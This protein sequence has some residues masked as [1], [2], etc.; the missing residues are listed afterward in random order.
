MRKTNQGGFTLIELL[1]VI[2]IIAILAAMLLPALNGAKQ[3]A[4]MII[5]LNNTKELGLAWAMYAPDN[6]DIVPIN[7]QYSLVGNWVLGVEDMSGS[8]P[9][10]TNTVE[11]TQGTINPYMNQNLA[12]Y[13]CP[14]DQSAAPGQSPR[15]R[16][17]SMNAFVGAVPFPGTTNYQNFLHMHDFRHTSTTYTIL[18]EHPD[19]INDG[20]YLPILTTSVTETTEWEDLAGSYHNHG[21]SFVYADGHSEEHHWQVAGTSKPITGTYS[22]FP[23]APPTDLAWMI[24]HMSPTE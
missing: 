22:A 9:V 6:Q 5:C 2:A 10:N 7:E 23:A 12:S 18:D 17:Y 24:Q 21:C 1:V 20:W 8:N 4:V 14:S 3:R 13:H 11:I 15:I 19:S 16:S